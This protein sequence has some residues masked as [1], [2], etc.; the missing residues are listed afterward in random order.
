V[1][2]RNSTTLAQKQGVTRLSPGETGLV[3][4]VSSGKLNP[5]AF[6]S[7]IPITASA[8]CPWCL[9][10]IAPVTLTNGHE[11]NLDTEIDEGE[12]RAVLTSP[13]NCPES[14]RW[15][16]FLDAPAEAGDTQ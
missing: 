2:N 5:Q 11:I 9:S 13:H 4:L 8:R 16:Q 15:G 14:Q 6:T 10:K 1:E 7:T 3:E 12:L